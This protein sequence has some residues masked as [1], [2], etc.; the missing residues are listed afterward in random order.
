MPFNSFRK[1]SVIHSICYL[2]SAREWKEIHFLS[3]FGTMFFGSALFVAFL[4]SFFL[5]ICQ[6]GPCGRANGHF[7]NEVENQK[8]EKRLFGVLSG[9]PRTQSR[10]AFAKVWPFFNHF[11]CVFFSEGDSKVFF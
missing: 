1:C 6:G 10:P 5:R 3:I 8:V 11:P 9:G 4:L 2:S 7:L